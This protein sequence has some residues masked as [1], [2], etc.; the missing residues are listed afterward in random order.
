MKARTGLPANCDS[1]LQPYVQDRF[2]NGMGPQQQ[3][4]DPCGTACGN[5]Q[6]CLPL[7]ISYL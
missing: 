7:G 1:M 2:S 3:A 4:K 5:S 6:A